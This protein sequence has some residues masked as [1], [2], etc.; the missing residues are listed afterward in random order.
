MQ[1]YSAAVRICDAGNC[2][3]QSAMIS[4]CLVCYLSIGFPVSIRFRVVE[5]LPKERLLKVTSREVNQNIQLLI[6][7]SINELSSMHDQS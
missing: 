7:F 4:S 2:Q 5:G 6:F 1:L 3:I